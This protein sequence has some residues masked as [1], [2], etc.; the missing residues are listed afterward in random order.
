MRDVRFMQRCSHRPYEK[1]GK[2]NAHLVVCIDD[3]N[4]TSKKRM[5]LSDLRYESVGCILM[6]GRRILCYN[7]G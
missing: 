3:E 5:N 4:K 1:Q 2:A 7:C 6:C